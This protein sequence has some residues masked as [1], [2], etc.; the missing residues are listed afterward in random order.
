MTTIRDILTRYGVKP[1]TTYY[2]APPLAEALESVAE[3]GVRS[4]ALALVESLQEQ[5]ARHAI[6]LGQE[7]RPSIE[8]ARHAGWKTGVEWMLESLGSRARN[9]SPELAHELL[10]II[11]LVRGKPEPEPRP[12]D[13][14]DW[15]AAACRSKLGAPAYSFEDYDEPGPT[16]SCDWR[17]GSVTAE[18]FTKVIGSAVY[19]DG[20][21]REFATPAEL[22]AALDAIAG[23]GS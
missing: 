23:G 17:H 5:L 16:L 12:P 1:E 13:L 8:D 21:A 15:V 6:A 14:A 4:E 22:R 7:P 3:T 19:V 2:D 10:R 9:V 11:A 18:I 20:G